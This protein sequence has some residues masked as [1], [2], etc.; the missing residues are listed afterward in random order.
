MRDRY[1]RPTLLY[2]LSVKHGPEYKL[3]VKVGEVGSTL[4][5]FIRRSAID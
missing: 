2:C 3:Q 5:T 1:Y 4:D